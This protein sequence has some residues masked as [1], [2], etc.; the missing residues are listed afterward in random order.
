MAPDDRS[1]GLGKRDDAGWAFEPFKT[2]CDLRLLGGQPFGSQ[3]MVCFLAQLFAEPQ[4][5]VIERVEAGTARGAH[6][7]MRI[8]P[9]VRPD[10]GELTI[11]EM[12]A[13]KAFK[14]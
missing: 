12:T 6:V 9:A 3:K 11:V 4:H 7:E 10:A 5:P 1:R 13:P 14:K 2:A 8:A